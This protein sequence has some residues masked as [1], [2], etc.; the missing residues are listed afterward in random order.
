MFSM[1]LVLG[2]LDD[3]AAVITKSSLYIISTNQK[4]TVLYALR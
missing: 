2:I 1:H 4:N 3:V